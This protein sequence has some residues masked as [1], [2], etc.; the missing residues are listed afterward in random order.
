MRQRLIISIVMLA[1]VVCGYA[2][3]DTTA[4]ELTI[5]GR[6]I[7][8][9]AQRIVVEEYTNDSATRSVE[10][11]II[12]STV[13]GGCSLDSV[14]VGVTTLVV[15]SPAKIF[16]PQAEIVKFDGCY[17]YHDVMASV[18]AISSSQISVTTTAASDFGPAGA[19]VALT[20][21]QQSQFISCDGLMLS[22]GDL[23]IGD[24]VYVRAVGSVTAPSAVMLQVLN[25]CSQ[26]ASAECTFIAVIDSSMYLLV[27]GSADT[28]VLNLTS[29]VLRGGL[30]SDSTLPLYGC[31]GTMYS[32]EDLTPGLAMSVTYLV[33]PRKGSVLQY[34]FIKENCPVY[35]NG[36]ITRIQSDVVSISSMGQLVDLAIDASTELLNCKRDVITANDLA[37][38]QFVDGTAI[39]NNGALT[40]VRLTV[41]DD[42]PYAYSTAGTVMS[43]SP[44]ELSIDAFDPVSG[45]PGPI[46]LILDNATQIVD[47]MS[48]PADRTSITTGAVVVVYYR[49]SKGARVAD[50]VII[51]NPCDNNS[52]SGEIKAVDVEK[53]TVL[54]DKGELTSFIV[55]SSSVVV[56]CRG[57]LVTINSSLV[58]ARIEGLWLST[59]D[60]NNVRSATVY[61]D[62][63]QS[64]I[65]TGTISRVT[66]SVLSVVTTDGSRDVLQAPYTM[67]VNEAGMIEDWSALTVGRSVCAVIDESNQTILRVLVDV[68]CENGVRQSDDASMIVGNIKGIANGELTITTTS[69]DLTFAITPATQMMNEQRNSIDASSMTPGNGVRIVSKNH[70]RELTPIA[71]TVVLLS[72]TSVDDGSTSMDNL[73][74]S[75]NPASLTVSFSSTKPFDFITISNTLGVVIA[76]LRNQTTYNVADLPLG[77]YVVSA[78]RG[79]LLQTAIMIR[80]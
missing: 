29:D 1:S 51:T 80:Q 79:T 32:V 23:R 66:D 8:T 6:L 58:G 19:D 46:D 2:Q 44:S 56:N 47:C 57:E 65:V 43:A 22:L 67:I 31:D 26:V 59:N 50:M 18:T 68:I 70:T 76:E 4:P 30:P 45:Q 39:K 13:I 34:A 52:F 42:C 53:V 49:I 69:G 41:M 73:T 16:P 71:S 37:V 33:S 7:Q 25:D 15:L 27:D 40:A 12:P 55:D 5:Y 21:N 11:S 3:R 24:P 48:L 9:S 61:V 75:P 35:V 77:A 38:G 63:L 54:L 64:G 72:P 78:R 20:I 36:M 10:I 28:L 60:G 74:I 62:C 14:Q 17:A